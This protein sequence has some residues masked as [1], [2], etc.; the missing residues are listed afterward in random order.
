VL[1][2]SLPGGSSWKKISKR[3]LSLLH[4]R[5]ARYLFSEDDSMSATALVL[6][7]GFAMGSD[8]HPVSTETEVRFSLDRD[9]EG[10]WDGQC[11]GPV[12]ILN[13]KLPRTITKARVVLRPNGFSL[14]S[15]TVSLGQGW[16]MPTRWIDEGKGRFRVAGLYLGIYK[17]EA[18]RVIICM[19]W[20]EHGRPTSF[21]AGDDQ[22]LLILKPAKK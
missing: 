1:K 8:P 13:H 6:L 7:A 22:A 19:K 21:Q 15:D 5:F 10:S 9:W 3:E 20:A 18:D 17:R 2:N 4:G 12:I 14:S 11:L 16:G